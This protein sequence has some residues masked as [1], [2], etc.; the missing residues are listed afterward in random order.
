MQVAGAIALTGSVVNPEAAY[1]RETAVRLTSQRIQLAAEADLTISLPPKLHRDATPSTPR[2]VAPIDNATSLP[3]SVPL[4][5]ATYTYTLPTLVLAPLAASLTVQPTAEPSLHQGQAAVSATQ[6][7]P[8]VRVSRHGSVSIGGSERRS[9][10]CVGTTA[11]PRWSAAD[12]PLPTVDPA[13]A[14]LVVLPPVVRAVPLSVVPAEVYSTE[15]EPRCGNSSH[16]ESTRPTS[17]PAADIDE[18][19]ATAVCDLM[20][21]RNAHDLKGTRA[22]DP[23]GVRGAARGTPRAGSASDTA[24]EG[25]SESESE[26]DS[27]GDAPFNI[28][29]GSA[30]DGGGADDLDARIAE[31]VL[32]MSERRA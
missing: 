9:P 14:A 32:R 16:I 27:E 18:R 24:D 22:K 12:V 28:H 5:S 17:R 7:T 3:R 4:A 1:A 15:P 13:P 23:W 11:P 30:F 29:G 10:H 6:G 2:F 25:R 20:G 31:V 8:F 19:I 26:S 21:M